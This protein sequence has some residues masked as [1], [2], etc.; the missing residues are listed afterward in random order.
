MASLK[1][2]GN[3]ALPHD[4]RADESDFHEANETRTEDRVEDSIED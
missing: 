3:H 1:E 2:I 4:T